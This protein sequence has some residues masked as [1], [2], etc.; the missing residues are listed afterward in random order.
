IV[1]RTLYMLHYLDALLVKNPLDSRLYS[2]AV[3]ACFTLGLSERCLVYLSRWAEHFPHD[4]Q[5][6]GILQQLGSTE[7]LLAA[8]YR[9]LGLKQRANRFFELAEQDLLKAASVKPSPTNYMLL[10]EMKLGQGDVDA[11]I[12][13]LQQGLAAD[14]TPREEA[15][16][17]YD[18]ANIDMQLKKPEEA[19]RHFQRV[20]MLDPSIKNLWIRMGQA[21]REL[22][23]VASAERY[24]T[25]ALEEDPQELAPYVSLAALYAGNNDL[26]RS[27]KLVDEGLRLHPDSVHLRALLASLLYDQGETRRAEAELRLAEQLDPD[28]PLVKALRDVMS[29][30]R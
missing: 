29:K 15:Q 20:E 3:G 16:V 8:D 24:L 22:K 13:Y 23:D 11:A 21:H 5:Y 2:D 10:G 26:A 27:R 7:A 4:P 17:E 6:I 14:P 18:L 25:R 12:A 1:W 9:T 19:L 30:A 28:Y